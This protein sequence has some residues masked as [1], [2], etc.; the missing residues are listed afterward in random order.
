MSYLAEKINLTNPF[1]VEEVR[2]FL[3]KFDL[4]FEEGI[5]YTV[6]VRRDGAVVATCSKAKNILKCF[7]VDDSM[8]GKGVTNIMIKNLQDKLFEE[9]IF[10]SFIFTK[11]EYIN[12][13]ESLGYKEVERSERVALLEGGF[14][15]IEKSLKELG[16]K[17]GLK[18]DTSRTALVM[19]CNPFTLGHRYLIER[20]SQVSEEVVV[21]L[22]EEDRSLFPF[23][24][25]LELV[26][27]GVADLE[28]VRVVPGGEY[29][30]SSATFPA[31]FLREKGEHL[32]EYTTLDAKIFGRYF[33]SYFNIKK[34][35]VGD[36]PYCEVTRAYNEALERIL[37][38]YGVEV[39][40]VK[41][42]E[43]D[44]R[45]ISA[46]R[47][48]GSIKE[49]KGIVRDELIHLLPETTLEFLETEEGSRIVEKIIVS[50]TAH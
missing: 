6:A 47:V 19:N 50:N 35:M 28:N 26:R 40:I 11:P 1:E 16:K 10:H 20:A 14:G 23:K 3:G 21:F 45:A 5:D 37:K 38:T 8:Q 43:E 9:G 42:K 36:E 29:I 15:G 39:E 22:V 49:N 41:R 7:A 32:T 25:R 27:R 31:Y 4:D 46:S 12:T 33:C 17:Y 18:G 24:T 34:R 48:R 13:F 2:G 44:D 30:I